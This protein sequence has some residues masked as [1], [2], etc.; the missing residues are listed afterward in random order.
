MIKL[1]SEDPNIEVILNEKNVNFIT[2]NGTSYLCNLSGNN[3]IGITEE[4]YNNIKSKI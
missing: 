4:D 1:A 3:T 2:F